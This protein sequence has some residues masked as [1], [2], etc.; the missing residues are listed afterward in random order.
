MITP[1]AGITVAPN[2]IE[3]GPV[4][5]LQATDFSRAIGEGL[6]TLN[7]NLNASDEVLRGVAAG[8]PMPLHDVM[9]VMTRAQ[10]SLQFAVEVRNRLVESYQQLS[11]MQL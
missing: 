7:T 3:G 10:L 1:V 4:A 9:I 2:L 8:E 11:Q 6:K 5:R